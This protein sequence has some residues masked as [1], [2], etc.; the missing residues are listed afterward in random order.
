VADYGRIE[1]T[2]LGST[3]QKFKVRVPVKVVYEW[4]GAIAPATGAGAIFTT[5]DIN[6]KKTVENARQK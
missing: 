3:V 1:Y 4:G 2:N 6:V 5:V